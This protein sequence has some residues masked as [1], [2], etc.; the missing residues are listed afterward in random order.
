MSYERG[1][2]VLHPQQI[3]DNLGAIYDTVEDCSLELEELGMKETFDELKEIVSRFV[4]KAPDGKWI[5]GR[6][7]YDCARC[8]CCGARVR[9]GLGSSSRVRDDRCRKCG[10]LI[11]WTSFDKLFK[12]PSL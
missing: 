6:D 5:S 10:Q 8:P 11:D 4:A 9:S 3:L 12:N 2:I 7:G 1:K